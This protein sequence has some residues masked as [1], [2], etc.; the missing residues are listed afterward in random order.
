MRPVL[1]GVPVRAVGR[2]EPPGG[3]RRGACRCSGGSLIPGAVNPA[4]TGRMASFEK[5][6]IIGCGN[7]GGAMLAGW[8]AAGIAPECFAVL[9]PVL[10]AAPQGVRLFREPP[11]QS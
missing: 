2:Q 8:L 5:I 4:G 10:D 3:A 6:L 9:D 11:A 7:M 1:S